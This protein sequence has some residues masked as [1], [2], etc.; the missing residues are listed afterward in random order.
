MGSLD[1][2]VPHRAEERPAV[3]VG[4]N[5]EDVGTIGRRR[6][7]HWGSG[8]GS[9]G[10]SKGTA[11]NLG[12]VPIV[13]CVPPARFCAGGKLTNKLSDETFYE[14]YESQGVSWGWRRAL[15]FDIPVFEH[16]G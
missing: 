13:H 6:L 10:R 8:R 16:R 2:R 5:E 7:D 11:R 12:H 3:F 4:A 1:D 9:H 14:S 15:F